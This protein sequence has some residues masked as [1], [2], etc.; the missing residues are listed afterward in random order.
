MTESA[1]TPR[2]RATFAIYIALIAATAIVGPREIPLGWHYLAGLAGFI[3]VAL[4][5]LGRIWCSLFIAGHKD[6]V[7]VTNGPYALCR[8]PLYSFSV[9]GALGLGLTSRSALLCVAVVVLIMALVVYAAAC[10]EQFLADA[11]PD[12]FKAYLVATPNKWLP[13]SAR[14]S[15][16]AVL[17]VRPAVFWKAFLDA[18]SFFVLWVL[19]ALA[20]EYRVIPTF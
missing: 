7:L 17:D 5:C 1:S 15:L 8:H 18:G 9:L 19:V 4:A 6:E 16:P 3:F 12:E 11:F 10:E 14:A 20:A 13:K 2:L